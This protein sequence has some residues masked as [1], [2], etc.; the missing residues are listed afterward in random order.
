MSS[1]CVP[2]TASNKLLGAALLHGRADATDL[3][4]GWKKFDLCMSFGLRL[5][6]ETDLPP[7]W[8][9]SSLTKT[10]RPLEEFKAAVRDSLF[11]SGVTWEYQ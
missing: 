8:R 5:V 7:G 10:S 3:E 4:T 6:V 11:T 1:T 2:A 9:L